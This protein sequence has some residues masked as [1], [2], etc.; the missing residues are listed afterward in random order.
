LALDR[1]KGREK[2]EGEQMILDKGRQNE[3]WA[4]DVGCFRPFTHLDCS[5]PFDHH[6]SEL[7]TDHYIHYN[8]DTIGIEQK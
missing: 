4:A 2:K 1:G 7:I 6:S 5:Q 3:L 8:W